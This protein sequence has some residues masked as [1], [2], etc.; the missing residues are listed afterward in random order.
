MGSL[1]TL[2]LAGAVCRAHALGGNVKPLV[3]RWLHDMEGACAA[4]ASGRMLQVEWQAMIGALLERVDMK[5]LLRAISFDQLAERAVRVPLPADHESVR[6][7]YFDRK[8]GLPDSL[9]FSAYLFALKKG[10]SVVP[11]GHH[12][13]VTMHMMLKGSAHARHFDRVSD[14]AESMVIRPTAD[15]LIAPG[16][17]TSISDDKDNIHWFKALTEPVFMFNIGVARVDPSKPFGD[18]DYV[19]PMGGEALGGGLVRARRL[20]KSQAYRLYGQA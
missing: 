12:N 19:D 16:E 10:V 8:E 5:D 14:D 1:L 6:R 4:V 7:I 20:A 13:M 18:R 17:V 9:H 3:R 2:A 15:K 11:H